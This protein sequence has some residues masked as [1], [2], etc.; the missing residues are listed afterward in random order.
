MPVLPHVDP[1]GGHA[2]PELHFDA[3]RPTGR[4]AH[5]LPHGRG[6]AN[7]R[8]S[9]AQSRTRG[10]G[11]DGGVRPTV[12]RIRSYCFLTVGV[13]TMIS[14]P[15]YAQQ[16]SSFD[17]RLRASSWAFL[18]TP[19]MNSSS[20][21]GSWC[22]RNSRRTPASTASSTTYT[23]VLWPQWR[24]DGYSCGVY[25]AS[26]ITTSAPCMYSAWRRSP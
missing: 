20:C 17:P 6:S 5:P 7:E 26:W 16:T 19:A 2:V 3:L 14:Q 8:R 10:S 25:C 18:S 4:Y 12:N 21:D 22:V 9:P 15:S 24:L 11:A 23:Y 1:A 13:Q